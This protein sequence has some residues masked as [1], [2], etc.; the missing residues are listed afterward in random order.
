MTT[1]LLIIDMQ[2]VMQERLN[3]GRER[4]N[5][6]AEKKIA[7]LAATVPRRPAGRSSISAIATPTRVRRCM[8][9]RP[10]TSR[11][12]APWRGRTNL[13]SSSARRLASPST[14]LEG[15]LH[16]VGITHLVVA[17]AVAGFCV[18][19]TVRAGSDLGFKMSVV[20]DAVLGFDLPDARSVG[21]RDLR[22]DDGASEIRFRRDRRDAAADGHAAG[23]MGRPRVQRP[24]RVDS[25]DPQG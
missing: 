8:R 3:A 6:E 2:M 17:G 14:E 15:Y 19:T 11:C 20:S 1:A 9:R 18:N 25:W 23:L 13:F 24:G 5:G 16:E 21:P 7:E 4:V 12:P 10:A 22:R